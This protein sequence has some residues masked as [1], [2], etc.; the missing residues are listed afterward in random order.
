MKALFTYNYGD[1]KMNLIR[2]LGYEVILKDEK[3]I[4]YSDDIEDVEVFVCYNPF[5]TLDITK[6]KN[7]KWIQ[8]SSIG[9][10]QVPAEIILKN[11]IILT[12][13]RGG[14]SIPMGEWIV[15]KTLEIYKKS[16]DL[17][18]QQRAKKWKMNTKLLELYGKNIS[19]I[20]TGSIA[21]E[22][23]KRFQGFEANIIG[24]NTKGTETS[25]FN[26]CYSIDELDKVLAIS[27]VVILTIPYTEDTHHLINRD[28]LNNMKKDAVLINV[29]R[30]SIIN[31]KDLIDHLKQGNL[32][33]AAL[34]VFEEEPLPAE[35][36]LWDMEN[37]I[38][39]PHN[40]W[41]S[42]MRDERR[43]KTIFEN[44]ER[45]IRKEELINVV[46]LKRGY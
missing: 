16:V 24:I 29:S 35:N 8:L 40:S 34:D 12:N 45:Y 9:V 42:E 6:M 33:G 19:F 1:E 3:N 14:Y 27:D 26:K 43:F 13:N 5:S 17:Y 10:D 44:M 2:S 30:G 18:N 39:T 41:M 23:A 28:R 36:P 15:L 31:E 37:V 22:S 21:V 11:N 7:L 20:G 4:E 32:L 38:I 25:Y 46:N